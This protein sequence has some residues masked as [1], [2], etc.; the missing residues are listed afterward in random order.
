MS[1][2]F[3]H[4]PSPN[5]TKQNIVFLHGWQQNKNSFNQLIPFLYGKHNI[6][7]ID[8]PGFGN[9]PI[10]EKLKNSFD[11]ANH[12]YLWLRKNKKIK[13]PIVIG[14][15][16]GGKIASIIAS[17]NPTYIKKLIL[18]APAGIVKQKTL[19]K[20]YKYVPSFFKQKTFNL[21]ASRDYKQSGNL[22]YLFKNIVKENLTKIFRAI[23]TPTLIIWGDKDKE[24]PVKQAFVIHKLIS[25]SRLKIIKNG[26]H[27]PFW[28]QPQKVSKLIKTFIQ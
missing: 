25:H 2:S 23:K 13:Q 5:P 12:I 9:T 24:L 15:S 14:H 22:L 10:N 6:Y 17:Q 18:I 27:F 3:N 7:S 4:F 28:K 26:N 8:L 11:Y 19:Y 20:L 16:F 1:I 21:I